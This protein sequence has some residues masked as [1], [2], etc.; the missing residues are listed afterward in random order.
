MNYVG[1]II[2]STFGRVGES[3]GFLGNYYWRIERYGDRLWNGDGEIARLFAF[4]DR[5]VKS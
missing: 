3:I 1:F 5:E 4:V 2:G